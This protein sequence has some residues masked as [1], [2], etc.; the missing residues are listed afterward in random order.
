MAHHKQAQ[1]VESQDSTNRQADLGQS[2]SLPTD[3]NIDYADYQARKQSDRMFWAVLCI[4][5]GLVLFLINLDILPWPDW[6][7]LWSLWPILLVG[8]GLSMLLER[9]TSGKWVS[10]SLWLLLIVGAIGYAMLMTRPQLYQQLRHSLPVL[11][12]V[13]QLDPELEGQVNQ[14]IIEDKWQNASAASRVVNID[15]GTGRLNVDTTDS[16]RQ[17]ELRSQ[18]QSDQ[19]ATSSRVTQENDHLTIDL[20]INKDRSRPLGFLN[21]RQ[22]NRQYALRL[23]QPTI[24]TELNIDLGA[25]QIDL[26]L[27]KK[28]ALT[29]GIWNIGAGQMTASFGLDSLPSQQLKL[30][31]GVGQMTIRLPRQVGLTIHHDIGLGSFKVFDQSISQEGHFTS[32]NYQSAQHKVQLTVEVGVGQLKI[33]YLD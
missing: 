5:A 13:E 32:Q 3:Q 10:N 19:E 4:A 30:E 17:L 31:V 21:P 27:T 33:E 22:A 11:P 14:Q 25:G 26:D 2:T 24:P 1:A 8:T 6:R 16:G 18:G 7:F 23:G 29:T 28:L 12:Y 9:S 20:D 15:M